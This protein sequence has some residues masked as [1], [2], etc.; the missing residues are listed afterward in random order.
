MVISQTCIDKMIETA[1]REKK[2]SCRDLEELIRAEL[3]S[4]KVDELVFT[5]TARTILTKGSKKFI[6]KIL[7]RK[8]WVI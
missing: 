1:K 5:Q 8:L 2:I 6:N 4:S 3:L 7:R